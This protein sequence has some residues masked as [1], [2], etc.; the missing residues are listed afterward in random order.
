MKKTFAI[1]LLLLLLPLS[2]FSTGL[3]AGPI[4]QNV[5]SYSATIAWW[6]EEPDAGKIIYSEGKQTFIAQSRT[7]TYQKVRITNLKPST[8][9]VYY[10]EG[11]HYKAGPFE[12]RTAPRESRPFR[13]AVYGDT[14]TQD[15]IHKE[16][17]KK[18][19]SQKPE[20]ALHTGDLVGDGK[21]INQWERFFQISQ[22]LLLSLP[23]YPVL[24]NHEGNSPLY[25]RFF[26]L[27]GRE[28][29]YSFNWGDCHFIA[30]DS[31]EP[32]L[33][34]P[35]QLKWLREDLQSHRDYPYIIVFFHH[36][37]HTLVKGRIDFAKKVKQT[38]T[39]I[40]EKYMVSVVFLGHD[41]CYAHF[42]LNGVHYIVTG[43][44]GA[45]LYDISP[46]DKYTV[47]AEKTHNYVITD[48][49]EDKII[50]RA[51]RLNGSLIEKIEMKP[52]VK[53]GLPPMKLPQIGEKLVERIWL[54]GK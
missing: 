27:P 2:C 49:R 52:R 48:V 15:D 38:I 1:C 8:A 33:T 16:I 19:V 17:V 5:T 25:F 44:G 35:A 9:Y 34:D 23:L 28:R 29:Y 39:P 18:I 21:E 4:L 54:K 45:P 12:F 36:P 10:L 43:G 13:F 32:Y 42:L 47:K 30:L 50:L 40:L 14:R 22:P 46:P 26:S 6:T 20:L 7:A 37:P 31:N 11:N 53:R 3:K 24:G 41:H 51:F